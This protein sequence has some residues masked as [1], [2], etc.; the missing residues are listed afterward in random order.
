MTFPVKSISQVNPSTFHYFDACTLQ[1][2][3]ISNNVPA[4]LPKSPT[5]IIGTIIHKIMDAAARGEISNF[6]DFKAKWDF[7]IVAE[8]TKISSHPN[9]KHLV[10]LH[11]SLRDYS[12]R[13][14]KCWDS[15]R[16]LLG[17]H[18][19][20][21]EHQ[22]NGHPVNPFDNYVSTQEKDVFGY[23]DAIR[24]TP[25]GLE[26]IDYKSGN[27]VEIDSSGVK[28]V[29][30]D[31]V[32][33]LKVYAALYYHTFHQWP[34]SPLKIVEIGGQE[35]EIP[36]TQNEALKLVQDAKDL[37]RKINSKIL[38]GENDPTL[39]EHELSI[40]SPQACKYCN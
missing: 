34:V 3:L 37:I 21:P 12:T 25:S 35:F 24:A 10:P 14:T 38:D 2:I 5:A 28:Q 39:L 29:K 6:D 40:P 11:R 27:P 13:K 31:Y 30:P 32:L 33:Q 17:T 19:L 7:Y 9:L 1:G 26:L 23:I 15:V 18:I 4:M 20:K 36:Y 8:E 22:F 16:P